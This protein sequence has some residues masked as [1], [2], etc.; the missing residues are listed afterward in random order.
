M[1]NIKKFNQY[2]LNESEIEI[3]SDEAELAYEMGIRNFKIESVEIISEKQYRI[4]GRISG[5]LCYFD[6]NGE[7]SDVT[8]LNN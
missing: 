1:K 4:Y 6:I 5:E 7:I 3:L 2:K 8:N